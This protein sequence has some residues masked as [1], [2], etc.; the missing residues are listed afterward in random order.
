MAHTIYDV[1]IWDNLGFRRD[2]NI[3]GTAKLSMNLDGNSENNHYAFTHKED[4]S[5]PD[6]Y[7]FL[8]SDHISSW[9]FHRMISH[10]H[11]LMKVMP[12]PLT[13]LFHSSAA[14]AD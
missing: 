7:T 5:H 13:W 3:L 4:H 8:G 2:T 6:N 9:T 10:M 11:Q 1:S 14:K 12:F